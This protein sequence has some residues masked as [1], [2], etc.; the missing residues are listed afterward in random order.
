ML[1]ET[2]VVMEL[3]KQRTWARHAVQLYF[4]RDQKQREVDVV[5]E[6]AA[7]GVLLYS[8]SHTIPL[9]DRIWAVPLAGLWSP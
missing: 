2:F 5:I 7:G 1:L 4:Y 9:D 8:G 6:S 3:L